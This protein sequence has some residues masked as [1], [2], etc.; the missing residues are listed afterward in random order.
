MQGCRLNS[1]GNKIYVVI[2]PS[3]SCSTTYLIM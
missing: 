3:I 2:V 1:G